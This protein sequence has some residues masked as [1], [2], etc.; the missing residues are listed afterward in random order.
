MK[1]VLC[2]DIKN[3]IV[4]AY[5]KRIFKDFGTCCI[6]LTG[7][8][9]EEKELQIEKILGNGYKLLVLEDDLYRITVKEQ[10]YD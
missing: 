8:R 9:E 10:D 6:D 2:K 3:I 7:L 5:H 4:H 1:R